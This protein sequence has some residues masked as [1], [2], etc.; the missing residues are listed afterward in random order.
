M[1]GLSLPG[2]PSG[3]PGMENPRDS[4][5]TVYAIGKDGT[6]KVFASQ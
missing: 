5:L 3:V 4:S 2:M 6:T 1:I